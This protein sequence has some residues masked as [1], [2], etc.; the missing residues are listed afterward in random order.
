MTVPYPAHQL[1]A[2]SPRGS[3]GVF[4]SGLNQEKIVKKHCKGP[5][6]A[7]R[8][9]PSNMPLE[10]G[11]KGDPTLQS[12]TLIIR[13]EGLDMCPSVQVRQVKK[14]DCK[15]MHID[16]SYFVTVAAYGIPTFEGISEWN[17][18]FIVYCRIYGTVPVA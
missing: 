18:P 6:L 7:P 12:P 16:K 14:N 5:G 13:F 15:C 2:S 3:R 8:L 17:P 4:H 10:C 1:P 9:P 11:T